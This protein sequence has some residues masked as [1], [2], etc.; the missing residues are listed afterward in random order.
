MNCV[1]RQIVRFVDIFAFAVLIIGMAWLAIPSSV[2]LK[3]Y[4][5][6]INGERVTFV[7]DTPL[8]SVDV[9][10]V[11]EVVRLSPIRGPKL[12][13]VQSGVARFEELPGNQVEGD[14]TVWFGPC[15][16][17]PGEYLYR[18][19]FRVLAFGWFPLR[20][21]TMRKRFDVYPDGGIREQPNGTASH[22]DVD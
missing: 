9:R 8:G 21:V 14:K 7:R 20:P 16:D 22:E 18:V 17:A 2:F 19:S 6:D 13:C 10:W 15:I 11:G 4:D 5:L 12:T 1:N 3:P